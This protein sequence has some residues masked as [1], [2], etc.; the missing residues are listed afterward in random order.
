MTELAAKLSTLWPE[1]AVGVAACVCLATGLAPQPAV[2]K[3]TVWVAGVGLIVAGVLVTLGVGVPAEGPPPLWSTTVFVKGATCAVGLLLL[4]A[5]AAT[6][7]LHPQVAAADARADFEPG[8]SFRGEFF[9]FF[10]LSLMGLMLVSGS[11][12]LV[13]LFLALELTSLP[14]YVMVAIG[15]PRAAAQ[16]AAV[17]Y[18]FLGA[19]AAAVFLYGFTLIYGVSGATVLLPQAGAGDQLTVQQYVMETYAAGRAL[20]PLFV[21]GLVLAT[22]GI[23]FKIAAVPMHYY[24]ADVYEGASTPVTAFLAFVPKAAGF[25]ALIILFSA[26]S[27]Q[28]PPALVWLLWIM[29]AATMTV[30]NVLGLMQDSVKRVLAYSSIAHSGY[31]LVGLLAGPA[32]LVVAEAGAAPTA[33]PAITDGV[34][35]V[36][37]YLVGYALATTAAFTVLGCLARRNGDEAVSYA[38][39]GGLSRRHGPL[40]AALLIAVLSLI[41]LPPL[42]GFLGKLYLFGAAVSRGMVVLVVIGVLNSAIAAVYYLRIVRACYF[43]EPREGVGLLLT[44]ARLLAAVLAA[45]GAL[46]FG[47]LGGRLADESRLASPHLPPAVQVHVTSA[48]P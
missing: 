15:R 39:L 27:W 42:V 30:G 45:A 22:V 23:A 36:L 13:W 17:K 40:A 21:L 26:L 1:I 38:D 33:A 24:A 28:L 12:D 44:P 11:N 31:M 3:A 32:A 43:D 2:R 25:T 47:V 29:A 10:L 20:P 5:A 35:G 6:P 9:A 8:D 14:T 34:A 48:A 41:G 37:F 18:F 4:L 19:A 7:A 46:T 16:E